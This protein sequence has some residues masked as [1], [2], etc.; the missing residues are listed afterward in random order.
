M[1]TPEAFEGVIARSNLP[2]PRRSLPSGGGSTSPT[3][4]LGP[5]DEAA[6][7][8]WA[9]FAPSL[10]RLVDDAPSPATFA[11][12]FG[13]LDHAFQQMY[14]EPRDR[15]REMVHERIRR[16]VPEVLPYSDFLVLDQKL[17]VSVQ[18]AVPIPHGYAAY[19]P[20][21][22]DTRHVID[23]TLGVL[24]SE[25]DELRD[26]RLHRPAAV[27]GRAVGR[28]ASAAGSSRTEHV[29][30]PRLGLPATVTLEPRRDLWTT[31]PKLCPSRH[32]A[33]K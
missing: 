22:P 15:A 28:F 18:P 32:A 8:V 27:A 16:Q 24:L 3:E 21:R 10:L 14:R 11:H 23:I 2:G 17:A 31:Y 5:V 29:R 19:W 20:F 6:P 9:C 12:H 1:R 25:P 4:M 7:A 13:G 30:P 33:T 26:P